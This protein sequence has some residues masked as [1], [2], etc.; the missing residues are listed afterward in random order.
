MFYATLF[1]YFKIDI[2][3]RFG[4]IKSI[5]SHPCKEI[6]D[7]V[8]NTF[9][10]GVNNLCHILQYILTV[11]IILLLRS[12]VL[13]CMFINQ[14]LICLCQYVCLYQKEMQIRVAKCNL[15]QHR[16]FRISLFKL[17]NTLVLRL[18]TLALV[19]AKFS[20]S[21]LSLHNK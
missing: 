8:G 15:C 12:I 14:F 16:V 3:R 20:S 6:N 18:L 7:E 2:D 21:P 11:S 5:G 4:V 9:V 19:S 10:S 1:F 13:S 17:L